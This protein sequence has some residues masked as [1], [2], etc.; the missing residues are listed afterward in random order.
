MRYR[1]D[2]PQEIITLLQLEA[3]LTPQSVIADI[4]SGTGISAM[5]TSTPQRSVSSSAAPM[6]RQ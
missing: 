2:Y 5:K 6:P 1:P 3:A 4:G